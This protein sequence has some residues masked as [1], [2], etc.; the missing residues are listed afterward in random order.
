MKKAFDE[1]IS[2]LH[3]A[4]ERISE[5]EGITIKTESKR[6]KDL[7]KPGENIQLPKWNIYIM[8]MSEKEM[9]KRNRSNI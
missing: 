8:G 3:M 7:I 4:E 6:K 2:R 9:R 5:L 1:F